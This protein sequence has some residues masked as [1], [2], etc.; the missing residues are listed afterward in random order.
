MVR[1]GAI[2][3]TA[4]ITGIAAM[5]APCTAWAASYSPTVHN[6]EWMV[7]GSEFGCRMAQ[8]IPEF[9]KAVFFHEAGE[10][11]HFYLEADSPRMKSG[12]ASVK[13]VN[14]VWKPDGRARALGYVDVRQDQSSIDAEETLANKMLQELYAGQQVEFARQSW[15]DAAQTVRVAI[16]NVNFRGAY[17]QY[18]ACLADL[19]PVNL[20]QI[21]RTSLLFKPGQELLSAK[22]T[23]FLDDIL[24]Y[25]AAD[26][27]IQSFF[28]D[29]HSDSQG[30]RSENLE[31]SKRRAE[32]VMKYLVSGGVD[33]ASIV[34]RWHGE[35]YPVASNRTVA[36]RAKNRRVTARI[37]SIIGPNSQQK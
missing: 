21:E 16:S 33:R 1:L 36:G 18:V 25:V 30:T 22:E 9:G 7:E 29:G 4:V 24:L 2:L 32:K 27:S 13:V 14:P 37:V 15:Y 35:R 20:A 12:R 17:D 19:L 28:I 23:D 3:R 34:L 31:T 5:L 8:P 26:K 6:S 10:T 11:L